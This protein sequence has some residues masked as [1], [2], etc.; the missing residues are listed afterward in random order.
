VDLAAERRLQEVLLAAS[1]ERL[2]HSAHDCS[3]GGLLVTIAEAAMGSGYAAQGLGASL[4]LNGYGGDTTLEQV[5]F[6]EDGARAVVSCGTAEAERVRQLGEQHQVPV[7]HAGRVGRP[8]DKLELETRGR[9]LSWDLQSL[10]KTYFE[11]I[12]RRMQHP[13]VDRSVGE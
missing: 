9:L 12:P 8:E 1:R 13:D 5:L 2:L 3:E 7:F 10:R 4:S 11:A 6:A